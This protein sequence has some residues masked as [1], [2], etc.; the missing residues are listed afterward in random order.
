MIM[1]L[2]NK[3]ALI[4]GGTSGIGLATAKLFL[5]N[6]ANVIIAGQETA[7]ARKELAD[8]DD[9]NKHFFI[10]D[11]AKMKDIEQLGIFV[12][13]TFSKLDIAFLNAG[14]ARFAPLETI[15]ESFFNEVMNI[16]FKGAFFTLQNLSK[17]FSENA[18]VVLTAS[19]GMHKAHWGS[20]IYS[21]SKA[22][23]RSLAISLSNEWVNRGIRV[24]V[25][26]PGTTDSTL[27]QKLGLE[28]EKFQ[29]MKNNLIA[30]IPMGRLI[31]PEE[32]ANAVLYLASSGSES[33]TGTEIIID[34][35][36]FFKV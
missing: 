17:L 28:G 8:Y 36:A 10:Y 2:E 27:L 31:K 16:N 29:E 3:T 11:T 18:S 9:K 20:S 6:G 23:L 34:G 30:Q 25:V 32:I 19:A 24:N 13:D 26:S 35:G 22:S 7:K 14:V 4:T 1:H 15:S 33:Q 12:K 5:Q 21:A